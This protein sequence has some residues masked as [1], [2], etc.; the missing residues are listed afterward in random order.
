[1]VG[2]GMTNNLDSKITKARIALERAAEQSLRLP[3]QDAAQLLFD[4]ARVVRKLLREHVDTPLT[5]REA[6]RVDL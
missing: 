1:M 4:A 6:H 2:W 3:T 5:Q